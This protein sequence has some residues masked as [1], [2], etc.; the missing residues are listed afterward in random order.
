MHQRVQDFFRGKVFVLP[1]H[2]QLVE[3]RPE[4]ELKPGKDMG[5]KWLQHTGC[6]RG[7]YAGP[8][9]LSKRLRQNFL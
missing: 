6:R 7:N 8:D 1:G 4:K 5:V 9:V 2:H 3:A